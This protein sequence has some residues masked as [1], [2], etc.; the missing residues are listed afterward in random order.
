M[1][2]SVCIIQMLSEKFSCM[3]ANFSQLFLLCLEPQIYT[4]TLLSEPKSKM[5]KFAFQESKWVWEKNLEPPS[6][7]NCC[8][9]TCR[10]DGLGHPSGLSSFFREQMGKHLLPETRVPKPLDYTACFFW[11]SRLLGRGG[12]WLLG[13][14]RRKDYLSALWL[15]SALYFWHLQQSG[16]LNQDLANTAGTFA[17]TEARNSCC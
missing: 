5:G 16:L 11:R 1:Y 14:G 13:S 17:V 15:L 6:A 12:K 2:L 4:R 8:T 10:A 7:W 9:Q 3:L